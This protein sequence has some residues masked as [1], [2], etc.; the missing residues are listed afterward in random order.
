M[1]WGDKV[2]ASSIKLQ[3]AAPDTHVV[4]S[5]SAHQAGRPMDVTLRLL[6]SCTYMP[7]HLTESSVC[8]THCVG[9]LHAIIVFYTETR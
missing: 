9:Q 5:D 7:P 6:C 8:P 1:L 3:V 2:Q 4:G